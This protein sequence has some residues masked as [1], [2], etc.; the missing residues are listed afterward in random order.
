MLVTRILLK[1]VTAKMYRVI[2]DLRES[3]HQSQ[4]A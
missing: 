4:L 2:L 1:G 3:F